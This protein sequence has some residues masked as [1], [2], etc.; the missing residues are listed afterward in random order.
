L[1][2]ARP[3]EPGPPPS[4]FAHSP[5]FVTR[6]FPSQT[7]LSPQTPL[8]TKT[9]APPNRFSTLS[10]TASQIHT[11]VCRAPNP[12]PGRCAI[13]FSQP[14][15]RPALAA[16][17]PPGAARIPMA[18]GPTQSCLARPAFGRPGEL[19]NHS[20]NLCANFVT[21]HFGPGPADFFILS[22]SPL[23]E[24]Q[25]AADQV[26]ASALPKQQF[27]RPAF[28][29]PGSFLK[30]SFR[31]PRRSVTTPKIPLAA[32][33][34]V[35]AGSRLPRR[36]ATENPVRARPGSFGLRPTDLGVRPTGFC[37]TP[38]GIQASPDRLGRLQGFQAPPSCLLSSGLPLPTLLG[39]TTARKSGTIQHE[40]QRPAL[41]LIHGRPSAHP[42]GGGWAGGRALDPGRRSRTP[43]CRA[44]MAA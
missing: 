27:G 23:R 9:S 4:S 26:R 13:R 12:P 44:A 28:G 1:C 38:K 6:P 18:V 11:E 37:P 25:L 40:E 17:G 2:P 8:S 16:A 7:P 19:L 21:R 43:N 33:F 42:P 24:Q 34:F 15:L 3:G 30:R 14:L 36:P 31:L 39:P 5:N 29:R 10:T 32:E 41:A 35:L 20:F 22:G